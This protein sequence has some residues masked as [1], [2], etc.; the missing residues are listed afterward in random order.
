MSK[1]SHVLV[2]PPTRRTVLVAGLSALL[3]PSSKAATHAVDDSA[4][5]AHRPVLDMQWRTPAPGAQA[6]HAVDG[7]TLVSLSLDTRRWAGRHGRVFMVLAQQPLRCVLSWTTQGRLVAGRLEPGQRT[8]VYEGLLPALP[9]TDTLVLQVTADG[10]ELQA[11][12]QLRIGYE[13]EV[14]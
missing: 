3:W 5:V 1:S 2:L 8:L 6:S 9:L 12:Q 4:S 10:R 14:A 13:V 11:A 7:R